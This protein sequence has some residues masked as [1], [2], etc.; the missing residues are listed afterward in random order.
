MAPPQRRVGIIGGSM[1]GLLTAAALTREGCA[2]TVYERASDRLQDR[3]AGI[4][5]PPPIQRKLVE[6]GWVDK[7]L[8]SFDGLKRLWFVPDGKNGIG[9]QIWRQPIH[10]SQNSWGR[11]W[12]ALHSRLHGRIELRK[13]VNVQAIDSRSD[14]PRVITKDGA[15]E[16]DALIGADGYRSTVRSIL[17]PDSVPRFA[18]YVLWRGSYD[19]E[20]LPEDIREILFDAVF[21]SPCYSGGHMVIYLVP[22]PMTGRPWV[23]WGA[24]TPPLPGMSFEDSRSL[25]PGKMP[26]QI[27]GEASRML[28]SVLPPSFARLVRTTPRE[29]FALQPVYDHLSPGYA[30]G[31]VA[32]VG[33]AAS[34]ARPHTGGGVAKAAEDAFALAEVLK[35]APDWPTAFAAY[36]SERRPADAALVE[37]GRSMG[38]A[39]VENTPNWG[40]MSEND[41]S[42]WAAEAGRGNY[43]LTEA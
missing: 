27:T 12:H 20:L 18:G 13:G 21:A 17:F 22:D 38:Y 41:M 9:R 1:A 11:V 10:A 42:V 35:S 39:M 37:T 24:Y 29:A 43:L 36:E 26:A 4:S 2:V 23:N 28:D 16:F 30:S 34:V 40:A 14:R 7:D 25:A 5:L 15:I 32:L 19:A 3:G 31:A 6:G 8:A 33:D